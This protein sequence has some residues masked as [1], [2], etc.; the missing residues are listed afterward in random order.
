M[1]ADQTTLQV[2]VLQFNYVLF[3]LV[4]WQ[5]QQTPKLT[6]YSYFI[7]IKVVWSSLT[8]NNNGMVMLKELHT[9]YFNLSTW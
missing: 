2:N 8:I 1:S 7:I 6:E 5:T 9:I 3:L 4:L